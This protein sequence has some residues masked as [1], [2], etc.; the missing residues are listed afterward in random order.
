MTDANENKSFGSILINGVSVKC[1]MLEDRPLWLLKSDV[2][3]VC[4]SF[5]ALPMPHSKAVQISV[6]AAY[7]DVKIYCKA[8]DFPT[9]PKGFAHGGS[10]FIHSAAMTTFMRHAGVSE[11]DI[12]NSELFMNLKDIEEGRPTWKE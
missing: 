1:I 3:H 4:R 11:S 7:G 10:C 9:R 2:W 5:G 6:K 8:S 12:S